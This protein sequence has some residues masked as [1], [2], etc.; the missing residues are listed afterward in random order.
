MRA[1][2]RSARVARVGDTLV[3]EA[4]ARASLTTVA[5]ACGFADSA[6]L[7]REFRRLVGMPPSH[8]ARAI[9]AG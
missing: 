1:L 2:V 3:R 8:F 4:A 7:S 9:A 5:L 6:H